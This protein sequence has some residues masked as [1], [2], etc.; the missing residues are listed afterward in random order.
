MGDSQIGVALPLHG[1]TFKQ[2]LNTLIHLLG[3]ATPRPNGGG[4][5]R[6]DLPLP[7]QATSLK[8]ASKMTTDLAQQIALHSQR[9]R[10][11]FITRTFGHRLCFQ[12]IF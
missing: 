5:S 1:P 11:H 4:I 8:T 6:Q 3:A 7:M 9:G 10:A 12:G 2:S